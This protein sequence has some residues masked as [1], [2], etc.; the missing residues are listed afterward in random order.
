MRR[1]INLVEAI[2]PRDIVAYANGFMR[3]M[4]AGSSPESQMDASA[5]DWR[6]EPNYPLTNMETLETF[7]TFMEDEIQMWVDEGDPNRFDN[8][9]HGQPIE[10][11][12]IVIEH[13]SGIGS[14]ELI[15]G[16][17]RSGATALC[18]RTT[19]PAVVGRLRVSPESS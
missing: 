10:E 2:V 6:Y 11:P 8:M 7:K 18:G 15:D 14:G 13:G 1:W 3:G 16:W 5:F 17:H 19:V 4:G 12:V 9:I